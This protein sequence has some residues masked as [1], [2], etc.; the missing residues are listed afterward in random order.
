[1]DANGN[2]IAAPTTFDNASPLG[3]AYSKLGVVFSGPGL[4]Q[5]GAILNSSSFTSPAL[6]GSNFLAFS[7]IA[8][9]FVT[10]ETITF[11]T[12]MSFVSI[13]AS[14]LSHSMTFKME[15]FNASGSS[16]DSQ[17]L[18]L[19]SAGYTQLSVQSP[20]NI[21]SV[22]LTVTNAGP[23]AYVFDDFTASSTSVPEPSSLLLVACGGFLAYR[24]RR[25]PC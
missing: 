20:G 9:G 3:N 25:S 1:V 6:S 21:K 7:A 12:P 2:P 14:S 10:P 8:P 5:G 15:A 13:Y 11:N 24:R 18:T 17:T 16:L 4:D 22:V 23:N 19:S